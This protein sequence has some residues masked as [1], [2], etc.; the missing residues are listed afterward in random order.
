MRRVTDTGTALSEYAMG[1]S[2]HADDGECGELDR[3]VLDPDSR[4]ITHLVVEPRHEYGMAR[5]VPIQF[6][7]VDVEAVR[8]RCT[9]DAWRE[10]PYARE[11][12]FLSPELSWMEPPDDALFGPSPVVTPSAILCERVPAG[13]IE[14]CHGEHIH[15]A[16]GSIGHVEGV[17]VDPVDRHVVCMLLREGHLRGRKTVAVPFDDAARICNDGVHVDL[18]KRAVR[19]L[20][21][22][23]K[24]S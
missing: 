15:A 23:R 10:F 14:V 11:V 13:E 17:L 19:E 20:P 4:S 5:L 22:I 8:L 3:V 1:M 16:D 7:H 18:T 2:V 12:E 24:P 9:L 6:A 21:E